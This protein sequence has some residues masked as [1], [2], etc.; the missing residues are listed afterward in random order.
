LPCNKDTKIIIW[1][2]SIDLYPAQ[3]GFYRKFSGTENLQEYKA[4]PSYE[5]IRFSFGS[6]FS[7]LVINNRGITVIF[8]PFLS[9]SLANFK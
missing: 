3:C 1:L 8:P 5:S 6:E 4:A 7:F 2:L 9:F